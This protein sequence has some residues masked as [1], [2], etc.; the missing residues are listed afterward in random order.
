MKH[1]VPFVLLVTLAA[2]GDKRIKKKINPDLVRALNALESGVAKLAPG[3]TRI[4]TTSGTRLDLYSDEG[5]DVLL[6]R[7]VTA[8][9][10][11]RSTILKTDGYKV[12]TYDVDDVGTEDETRTVNL[13]S[14]DPAEVQQA[15]GRPGARLEGT[16]IV[17]P[18]TFDFQTELEG[19]VLYKTAS[20]GIASLDLASPHCNRNS[21]ITTRTTL[22]QNGEARVLP[23]VMEVESGRCTTDMTTAELKALDLSAV[24]FCDKTTGDDEVNCETKDMEHLTD[25]L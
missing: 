21:E 15:G 4:T 14:L 12:Y 23:T 22:T 25:G 11:N 5:S 20:S 1:F 17:A 19:G 3:Q 9:G 18:F 24:Y 8:T 2:C 7:V 10:T 6:G 13:E 16:R